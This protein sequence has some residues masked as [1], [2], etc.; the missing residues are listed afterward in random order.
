[1]GYMKEE[2]D[3]VIYIKY[4]FYT[5]NIAHNNIEEIH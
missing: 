5:L 1:M 3:K 2:I 4:S